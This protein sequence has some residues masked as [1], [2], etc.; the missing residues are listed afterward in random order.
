MDLLSEGLTCSIERG[1]T[2]NPSLQ[3]T[4]LYS[5]NK[6][7]REAVWFSLHSEFLTHTITSPQSQNP[8]QVRKIYIREGKSGSMHND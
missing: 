5:L 1:N 7:V 2:I 4:L 8:F 3:C 6:E